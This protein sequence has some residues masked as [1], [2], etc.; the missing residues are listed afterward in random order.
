VA[1]QRCTR[2]GRFQH[3][4]GPA[5]RSCRSRQLKFEQVSGRGTIYTYSIT[6]E[7]PFPGLAVPFVVCIVDLAEQKGLRM[8]ANLTGVEPAAVAIGLEV[9]VY[10]EE[11]PNGLKL[12]QFRP[13]P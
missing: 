12:P 10:F 3:P 1:I 4:P 8:L 11:L 2:C 7:A 5:C 13:A 6:Y 9:E